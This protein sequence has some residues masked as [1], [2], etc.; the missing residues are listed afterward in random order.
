MRLRE[1]DWR[2]DKTC[3]VTQKPVPPKGVLETT[4]T[5]QG[6]FPYEVEFVGENVTESGVINVY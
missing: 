5:E 2:L 1:L 3:Y 4:F 6:R